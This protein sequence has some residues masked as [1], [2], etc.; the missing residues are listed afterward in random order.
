MRGKTK[1]EI[2]AE[3]IAS[4]LIEHMEETMTPRQAKRM[5]EDIDIFS[6]ARKG[7]EGEE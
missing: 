7:Y 1:A 2:V 5:L 3:K 6:K 4:L